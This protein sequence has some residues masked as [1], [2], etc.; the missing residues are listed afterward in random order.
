MENMTTLGFWGSLFSDKAICY[1]QYEL[2]GY[3]PKS[4]EPQTIGFPMKEGQQLK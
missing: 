3:F 1:S 2:L 4:G